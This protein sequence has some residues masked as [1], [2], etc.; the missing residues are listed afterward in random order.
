MTLTQPVNVIVIPVGRVG[1][2]TLV[3]Y[4]N[5]LRVISQEEVKNEENLSAVL[6]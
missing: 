1:K 2:T 3:D 5:Q 4:H 6:A